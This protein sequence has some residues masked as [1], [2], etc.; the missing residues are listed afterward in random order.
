M[1]IRT[2]LLQRLK[3]NVIIGLANNKPKYHHVIAKLEF[4]LSNKIFYSDLSIDEIKSILLFSDA[5]NHNRSNWDW[6]FGEDIFDKE[7]EV[8]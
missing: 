3:P 1:I 5:E 7:K 2:N 4:T 6:R 8:C